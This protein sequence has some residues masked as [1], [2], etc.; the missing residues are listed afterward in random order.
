MRIALQIVSYI[1]LALTIIPSVLF[2]KGAMDLERV[3]MV[4]LIM[5][6][7]WFAVT[8]LWMGREKKAD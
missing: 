7:V 4:M 5:T 1:A 3:K 8:P 2:L 6:L